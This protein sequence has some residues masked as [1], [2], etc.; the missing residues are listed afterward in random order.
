MLGVDT[1]EEI[2]L[3]KNAISKLKSRNE[4]GEDIESAIRWLTE[5]LEIKEKAL[6]G[7]Q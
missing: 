3:L 6:T 2:E 1:M 4:K 7:T 5:L